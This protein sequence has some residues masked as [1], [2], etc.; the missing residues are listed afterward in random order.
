MLRT[1]SDECDSFN[2]RSGGRRPYD[3]RLILGILG[4]QAAAP[5]KQVAVVP[6]I[7]LDSNNRNSTDAIEQLHK[8]SSPIQFG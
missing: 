2:P 8:R 5:V 6:E 4:I 3:F 1:L 7:F